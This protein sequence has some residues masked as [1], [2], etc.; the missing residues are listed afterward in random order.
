MDKSLVGVLGVPLLANWHAHEG[1]E[2]LC[3]AELVRQVLDP[4]FLSKLL[5]ALLGFVDLHTLQFRILALFLQFV[6]LALACLVEFLLLGLLPGVVD[7]FARPSP[8]ALLYSGAGHRLSNSLFD[9]LVLLSLKL[10]SSIVDLGHEKRLKELSFV[11]VSFALLHV[12]VLLLDQLALLHVQ[13]LEVIFSKLHSGLLLSL[14]R[15]CRF[16][17]FFFFFVFTRVTCVSG[18]FARCSQDFVGIKLLTCLSCVLLDSRR[19][20]SLDTEFT[21]AGDKFGILFV[22]IVA[23]ALIFATVVVFSL[24]LLDS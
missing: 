14:L 16:L 21:C 13:V 4:V 12:H 24:D 1:I 20:Q 22:A 5:V 19:F 18:D 15:D 9:L 3:A 10:F 2:L 23:A 8:P 6:D 17:G 11:A 7:A